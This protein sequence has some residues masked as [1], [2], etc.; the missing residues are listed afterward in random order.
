MLLTV[1][2]AAYKTCRGEMKSLDLPALNNR[3]ATR[4]NVTSREES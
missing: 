4:R 2:W 3:C 1:P